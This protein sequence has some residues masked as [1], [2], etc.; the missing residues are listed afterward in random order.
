MG[1]AIYGLMQV[2]LSVWVAVILGWIVYAVALFITGALRGED[3][4]VVW[5]AL[6]IP[7]VVRRLG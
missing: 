3:M 1:V 7:Q 6:P 5:D 2:G 4:N